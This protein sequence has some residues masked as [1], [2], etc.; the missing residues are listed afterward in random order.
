MN[1]YSFEVYDEYA[2]IR[3]DRYLSLSCE[4]LS[5][6]Y[7]QK[8]I[9]DNAVL[10]DGRPCKSSTVL[11]E[12]DNVSVSVPEAVIPDILPE[13]I[14]LDILY[15]DDDVIVVNK[16]K[17]MV[18]HPGA[19]HYNGTLVN[20]LMYHCTSLSG[21]NGVL[22]PG[23]V[24]RIDKDTTGAVIACKNDISHKS[25]ADQ[26]KEHS[27]DREYIAIVH[28]NICEDSGTIDAPIGRDHRERKKMA[29]DFN[30]GK[31]AVTTFTV[32]ERFSQF[33]FI[34]CRLRTGRTHQI[35]VHM[36]YLK[37]PILGDQVYSN[38]RS[39]YNLTGQTLHARTLGFTHPVSG[40]RILTE[41]PVPDYF[42]RVLND[43]R[44]KNQ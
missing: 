10:I 5:R 6:S 13:D 1:E 20:A 32:L 42:N 4:E 44:I 41:A 17:G 22:R 43:L 30:D 27:V 24:H 35:R 21:I 29:V 12:G 39:R 25:I 31:E 18:V 7:I 34:K 15:E 14:P 11:K 9:K 28:G 8:L 38:S 40:E 37:H 26:L 19:G 23:I 3:V 33:T 2:G 16:P 36:A